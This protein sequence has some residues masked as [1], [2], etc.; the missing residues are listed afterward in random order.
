[1]EG[2]TLNVANIG[3]MVDFMTTVVGRAGG[4]YAELADSLIVR[5]KEG[6]V[7]PSQYFDTGVF[8][9][10]LGRGGLTGRIGTGGINVGGALYDAAKRGLDYA[11]MMGY[12]RDDRENGKKLRETVLRHYILGDVT[13][14]NTSARIASGVDILNITDN[15]GDGLP[16]GNTVRDKEDLSRR[17]IE[18]EDQGNINNTT[19]VLGHESYRDGF[20]SSDNK[21]ETQRAVKAH[22][23]MALRMSQYGKSLD[24]NVV[25]ARDVFEYLKANSKN[26]KKSDFSDYVDANY[27]SSKDF[28]LLTN[29]GKLFNDG[30]ARVIN[31]SG[32]VV[33]SLEDLGMT[34]DQQFDY[35]TSLAKMFGI[36]N[37]HAAVVINESGEFIQ[38]GNNSQEFD[39]NGLDNFDY[40]NALK[41]NLTTQ[42]TDTFFFMN[43][44]EKMDYLKKEVIIQSA[45]S[46]ISAGMTAAKLLDLLH[47]KTQIF[48]PK[49]LTLN[50]LFSLDKEFMDSNLRDFINLNWDGTMNYDA[51]FIE[52]EG[53]GWHINKL[54]DLHRD[55][56]Y[57]DWKK[58]ND[59][60]GRE[61]IFATDKYVNR[62]QITNNLFRGTAN[63]APGNFI[64]GI[65]HFRF[66]MDPFFDKYSD[67]IKIPWYNSIFEPIWGGK[68]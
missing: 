28:W 36:S 15:D 5:G 30:Y 23:E 13:Q 55:P 47:T 32:K 10:N 22:T 35:T 63:Y 2:I 61:V 33:I 14:E 52:S 67:K 51:S 18:I 20:E 46:G 40:I 24:Y 64:N 11:N 16:D 43:K 1:M 4:G 68:W 44:N 42:R 57:I 17:I 3:A 53:S 6:S 19:V 45:L 29:D 50:S 49:I 27:D 41:Y 8:E 31:E 58:W 54:D 9:L 39:R 38:L 59:N 25:L 34:A 65:T 7:G 26:G 66:D 21:L 37:F 48:I 12:A 56:D 62:V 60:K